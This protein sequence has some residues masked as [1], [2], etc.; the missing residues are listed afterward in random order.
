MEILGRG[1]IALSR[2][3]R[4]ARRKL[5]QPGS[6]DYNL[7]FYFFTIQLAYDAYRRSNSSR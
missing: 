6:T 7:D 4:S 3:G 5:E 1:R 2:F